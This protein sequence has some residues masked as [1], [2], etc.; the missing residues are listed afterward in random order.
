[1]GGQPPVGVLTRA[2]A[3]P[4]V[5]E[6]QRIDRVSENRRQAPLATPES[7]CTMRHE[8]GRHGLLLGLLASGRR[9]K[10]KNIFWMVVAAWIVG[11]ALAYFLA[12]LP[13][14]AIA[15]ISAGFGVEAR[16]YLVLAWMVFVL[17]LV[18]LANLVLA[19]TKID[20]RLTLSVPGSLPWPI[21]PGWLSW[22]IGIV[23]FAI[24]C[25]IGKTIFT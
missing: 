22:V 21:T 7:G 5:A 11:G 8:R 13:V 15:G 19:W 20:M 23:A 3:R 10:A 1:M 6:P 2:G 9:A 24:G 17:F 16:V 12:P 4:R 25:V 18:S 14:A